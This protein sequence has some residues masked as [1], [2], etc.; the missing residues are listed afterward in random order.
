[1]FSDYADEC[2]D[3]TLY[4]GDSREETHTPYGVNGIGGPIY[5]VII[6]VGDR[7]LDGYEGSD[8][9]RAEASAL[10]AYR[11]HYGHAQVSIMLDGGTWKDV[12]H[13]DNDLST[14]RVTEA[15]SCLH[16]QCGQINPLSCYCARY[17]DDATRER[18]R[19][20]YA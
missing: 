8:Y 17:M 7:E 11:R 9:T 12:K 16:P 6:R 13:L 1:M 4:G 5:G 2:I 10:N 20:E 15:G 18:Y 19:A 3:A 14:A